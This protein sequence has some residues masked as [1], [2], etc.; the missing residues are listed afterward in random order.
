[1]GRWR[2][3]DG[4]AVVMDAVRTDGGE[5]GEGCSCVGCTTGERSRERERER[6]ESLSLREKEEI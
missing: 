6:R 4:R 5:G 1:M 2:E 3:N